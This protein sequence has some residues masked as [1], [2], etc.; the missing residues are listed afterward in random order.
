GFLAGLLFDAIWAAVPHAAGDTGTAS[1]FVADIV[2]G[3][4]IGLMVA[5]IEVAARTAWLSVI[6]GKREGFQYILSKNVTTIG[7]DDRDAVSLGGDPSVALPHARVPRDRRHYV[8]QSLS[9]DV[10]T[11]VNGRP[12][13]GTVP[14]EDGDEVVLGTTRMLFR[15]RDA[16]PTV[17]A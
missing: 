11:L 7:R 4:A 14:L 15:S 2:V 9:P 6:S 5:L 16:A 10:L 12:V 17:A 13:N 8:L 1:R 3:I